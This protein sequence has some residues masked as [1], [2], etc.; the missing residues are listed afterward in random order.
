[1][2]CTVVQHLKRTIALEREGTAAQQ[3]ELQSKNY[4]LTVQLEDVQKQLQRMSAA[5]V[6]SELERTRLQESHHSMEE[7]HAV[8]LTRASTAPDSFVPV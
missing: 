8:Q 2:F 3:Q 5:L 6:S 7:R 1:V 4:S